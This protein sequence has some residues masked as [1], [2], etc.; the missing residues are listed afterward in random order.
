M[1]MTHHFSALNSVLI[2]TAVLHYVPDNATADTDRTI[3]QSNL[4]CSPMQELKNDEKER[5]RLATV[6]SI[7]MVWTEV[8]DDDVTITEHHR[9]LIGG[10]DYRIRK[11]KAWPTP[12]P[13]YYELHVEDE[14]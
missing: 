11:V 2:N 7:L 12:N 14:T 9:V 1:N 3:V 5:A 6:A 4:R 13:V 10:I 8:P